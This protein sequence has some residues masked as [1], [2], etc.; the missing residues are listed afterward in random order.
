MNQKYSNIKR[1]TT[2]LFCVSVYED[3]EMIHQYMYILSAFIIESNHV[4]LT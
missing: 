4:F 3:F 1:S 2:L